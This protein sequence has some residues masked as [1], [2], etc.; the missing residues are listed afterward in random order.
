MEFGATVKLKNFHVHDFQ[1]IHDSTPIAVGDVTCL[2]GK[3]ESG[4]TAILKALTRINSEAATERHFNVTDD[5]P[6][7]F[8]AAYR[9]DIKDGAREH[10]IVIEATFELSSAA[11]KDIE[12]RF[13]KDFL[14]P[15]DPSVVLHKGYAN[16]ISAYFPGATTSAA[17][18][19]LVDQANLPR[20]LT[21]R[22]SALSSEHE[23]LAVLQDSDSISGIDDL[24]EHLQQITILGLHQHIYNSRIAE[25]IPTFLYFDEYYQLKG[26]ENLNSLQQRQ[27]DDALTPPDYALLGLLELAQVDLD[28]LLEPNRT[29]DLFGILNAAEN[30]LTEQALPY[31]SQ[32]QHLQMK[33]DIRPARPGDPEGLREGLNIWGRIYDS[34]RMADTSLGSRSRGF[35][36]FISFL[37]WY[38][39][40]RTQGG[41]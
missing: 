3:N 22:L 28:E 13:G 35:L 37:A 10:A 38:S 18:R 17:L 15:S 33:F 20:D 24:Q 8:S 14:P 23:M 2:V 1:S 12:V 29:E 40:L 36:W 26:E 25:R 39:Q 21:D 5:Y 9:K 30:Y 11:I 32:N 16:S 4:K 19:H 7:R 6:R 31:W 34:K 27:A 41:L